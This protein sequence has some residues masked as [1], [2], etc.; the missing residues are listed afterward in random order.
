MTFVTLSS[1][2]VRIIGEATSPIVLVDP[3]GREVGQIALGAGPSLESDE[4]VLAEVKR[5]MANDDGT[6]MTHAQVMDY[7]RALTPGQCVTP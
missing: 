6:R 3:D 1:E 5:R 2:Q 7:L 4:A